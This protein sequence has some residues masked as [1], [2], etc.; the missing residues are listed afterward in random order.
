MTRPSL[1]QAGRCT[2]REEESDA[3]AKHIQQNDRSQQWNALSLIW[4]AVAA[5]CGA[6]TDPPASSSESAPRG[7]DDSGIDPVQDSPAD[8]T[9]RGVPPHMLLVDIRKWSDAPVR[10]SGKVGDV[11]R[12]ETAYATVLFLR[13]M[14]ARV[15]GSLASGGSD[16]LD[17]LLHEVSQ[18]P[19]LDRFLVVP[20]GYGAGWSDGRVT[21]RLV[22][23]MTHAFEAGGESYVVQVKLIGAISDGVVEPPMLGIVSVRLYHDRPDYVGRFGGSA[24]FCIVPQSGRGPHVFIEPGVEF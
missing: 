17:W 20:E 19:R 2:L 13:Y 24:R 4:L 5:S 23:A 9:G 7:G 6:R 11:L 22:E 8:V 10:C 18:K 12:P 14:W 15:Q 21:E 3:I 16:E 1:V